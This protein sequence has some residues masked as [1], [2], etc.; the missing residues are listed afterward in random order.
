[1]TGLKRPIQPDE[2]PQAAEEYTKPPKSNMPHQFDY[3]RNID[4][5]TEGPPSAFQKS[6]AGRELSELDYKG[7]EKFNIWQHPTI[8]FVPYSSEEVPEIEW[9][10]FYRHNYFEDGE[11]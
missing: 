10:Q 1:M 2:D 11:A 3:L 9:E 4:E 8:A 6:R 5:I 7:N